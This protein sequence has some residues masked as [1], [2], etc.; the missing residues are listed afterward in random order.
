MMFKV[1]ALQRLMAAYEVPKIEEQKKRIETARICITEN[2]YTELLEHLRKRHPEVQDY[3][4]T[5]H[6]LGTKTLLPFATPISS[7]WITTQP[8]D[9]NISPIPPN[10]CITF[11]KQGQ[12]NSYG[13]VKQI[14]WFEN[15]LGGVEE[16]VLI[17]PIIEV[18]GKK[19]ECPSRNF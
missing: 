11:K 13:L 19:V 5:P 18:Y 8:K 9:F 14:Y 2:L 12:K 16:A 15:G 7:V 6:P 17:E 10:N 1:C 3:R 4:S